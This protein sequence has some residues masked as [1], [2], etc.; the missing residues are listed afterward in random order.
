MWRFG[1]TAGTILTVGLTNPFPG[2]RPFG[3]EESH[4]FFGREGQ[5][6]EALMNLAIF[7]GPISLALTLSTILI[8]RK[9]KLN[10]TRHNEIRDEIKLRQLKAE[11]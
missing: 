3:F 1:A 8:S 6:D 7:A 11:A 5:S 10:E 9:Y 2:L 4:L